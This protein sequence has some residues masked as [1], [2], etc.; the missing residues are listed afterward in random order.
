ME[1]IL[2]INPP[3]SFFHKIEG[4]TG[5][6][7]PLGLLYLN[8]IL[9][10]DGWN[11]FVI[12]MDSDNTDINGLMNL[13]N[14]YRITIAGMSVFTRTRKNA[15]AISKKIKENY[16]EIY[17]IMGG[18][19]CTILP[20][21]ALEQ[22]HADLIVQGE[23]EDAIIQII[24]EKPKG[25]FK[26]ESFRS[27]DELPWPNRDAEF[28]NR[29]LYGNLMRFRFC[30]RTGV[31]SSSRG[32]PFKCTYCSR[33]GLLKY[34]ERSPESVVMELQHLYESGYN[35]VIF[36]DDN[37]LANPKRTMKIADLI[38]KEKIKMD[39]A[40]QGSPI[41]SD[42]LWSRLHEAYFS[43]VCMGV[44]HIKPEII[45]YLN[46]TPKPYK[47]E[48]RV[49]RTIE[50]VNK[51]DFLTCGSFILG[52]PQETRSD[53]LNLIQFLINNEFDLK[54]GNELLFS[55]GT[56][57]WNDAVHQGLFSGNRLYVR[58]SEIMPEKRE[59][60]EEMFALAWRE[61]IKKIPNIVKKLMVSKKMDKITPFMSFI[62]WIIK[63]KFNLQNERP[64][65]GYG[66]L[67]ETDGIV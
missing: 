11:S 1:N 21:E 64:R 40:I 15:Y 10:L 56:K 48:E 65:Q 20:E 43:I 25:I 3:H 32:C 53:A 12:D 9:K 5:Y 52:A 14:R 4:I 57:L 63:S 35:G 7:P 37:F 29:S 61:S 13:I 8:E 31:I 23:A 24:R 49:G 50:I 38:I 39:F 58:V 47:W 60:L 55:Y 6:V 28:I 30:S 62:R 27:L 33:V 17:M 59:Y 26:A 41:P 16:P 46:K 18:A 2:L 51:Y 44:E 67:G 66:L 54:N 34:R 42:E 19:H 45:K 22:S 36:N